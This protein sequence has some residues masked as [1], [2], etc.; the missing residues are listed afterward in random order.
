VY[1]VSA[2][3]TPQTPIAIFVAGFP[4]ALLPAVPALGQA[5]QHFLLKKAAIKFF[6]RNGKQLYCL[7]KKGIGEISI[8]IDCEIFFRARQ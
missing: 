3:F 5:V 8:K 4:K 6:F 7:C 1:A 2:Q